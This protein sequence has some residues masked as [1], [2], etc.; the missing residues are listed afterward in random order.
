MNPTRSSNAASSKVRPAGIARQAW[1]L[2]TAKARFKGRFSGR[3]LSID[4]PV[5]DR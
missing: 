2:Q 1:Q 3:I 5:A 4:E